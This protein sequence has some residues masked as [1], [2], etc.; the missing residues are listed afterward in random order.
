MHLRK[1]PGKKGFDPLMGARPR[2]TA[3]RTPSPRFVADSLPV[4]TPP[5]VMY[6]TVGIEAHVMKGVE[7]GRLGIGRCPEAVNIWRFYQRLLFRPPLVLANPDVLWQARRHLPDRHRTCRL[8][9]R[10]CLARGCRG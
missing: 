4:P 10:H 5:K 1:Y 9:R 2:A 8:K 6:D 7:A 3:S